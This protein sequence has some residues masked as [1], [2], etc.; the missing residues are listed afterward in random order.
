MSTIF[1]TVVSF[2]LL[3]FSVE[4]TQRAKLDEVKDFIA[5][6]PLIEHYSFGLKP[7]LADIF[8][9]RSLQDFD[10][11]EKFISENTCKGNSWLFHMLNAVV[12]LDPSYRIAYS[13]GGLALTIIISDY[14]G[15]SKIF[16]KGV[17]A[18]P[19]DWPLL[20]RAAYHALYEERDFA[21]ASDLFKR[22]GQFGGPAWTQSLANRLQTKA[23]QVEVGE[24]LLADLI[25]RNEDETVIKHMR[26]RIDEIKN[27]AE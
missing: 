8:W 5:P 9:V 12:T 22:A 13:A 18:F 4:S 26:A 21:K 7:Q 24:R 3:L 19:E 1:L 15:A 16:D 23:G 14:A 27:Q 10:F 17:K 2:I 25:K 6:P 11:C 20:F